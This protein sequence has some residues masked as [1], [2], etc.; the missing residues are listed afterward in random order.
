[1]QRSAISFQLSAVKKLHGDF[2]YHLEKEGKTLTTPLDRETPL[3]GQAER[4]EKSRKKN[5]DFWRSAGRAKGYLATDLH[6]QRRTKTE[7]FMAASREG[8]RC[9]DGIPGLT[10]LNP[11]DHVNPVKT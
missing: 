2:I 7:G 1:M 6:G 8:Q 11:E 9:L 4:A 10:G 3:T 5:K